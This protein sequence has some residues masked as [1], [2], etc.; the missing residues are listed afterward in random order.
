[1]IRI[2][3][4]LLAL[5]IIAFT[6]CQTAIGG[7]D[8][9]LASR[10]DS[11]SYAHGVN[12]QAGANG[13]GAMG[14]TLNPEM[15]LRGFEAAQSEDPNWSQ[16]AS[17]AFLMQFSQELRPRNGQPFTDDDPML[18]N[19]DSLSMALGAYDSYTYKGCG[20]EVN[21]EAVC[22]GI[23]EASAGGNR[24]SDNIYTQLNSTFDSELNAA[25]M[26]DRQAKGEEAKLKGVQFLATNKNEEGVQVTESGLQY[27]VIK[28]GSGASPSATQTVSVH[29]EGRLIDGKVFDSSIQRGEPTEFPVNRVIP[30]W[31]EGLQLMKLGAKY[32]FYIPTELAYGP[33]G[34]GGSIGPNETLIFDV[35]L[36]EIK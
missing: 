11:L 10:V 36:L 16:E 30:G 29:Y 33:Q 12:Y 24:L 6:A 25:L 3:I 19:P 4:G 27:K 14:I 1:M 35:E 32:Q 26:A 13:L 5:V 18:T 9:V 23:R 8:F 20:Y 31:T 22:A 15:Y 34:A 17:T 21:G 28:A 2:S 7:D